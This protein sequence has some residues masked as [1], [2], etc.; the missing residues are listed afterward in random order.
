MKSRKVSMLTVLCS[1]ILMVELVFPST[2]SVANELDTPPNCS[3]NPATFDCEDKRNLKNC[4]CII[5]E[6][7]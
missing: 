7:E 3:Y 1:L 5:V 2:V 6:Q 4:Y